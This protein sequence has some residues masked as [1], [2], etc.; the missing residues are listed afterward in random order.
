MKPSNNSWQYQPSRF[1]VLPKL[2]HKKFISK[3][4][5][6][7]KKIL[8]L[9]IESPELKVWQTWDEHGNAYWNGYDPI[10]RRS[11]YQVSESQ[12]RTWIEQRHH[13]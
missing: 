6:F 11:I 10:T 2:S 4:V 13:Q 3:L 5:K 12:I 7:G 8:H 9:T 1:V